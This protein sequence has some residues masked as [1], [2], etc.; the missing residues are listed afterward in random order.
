MI[1][2]SGKEEVVR[3]KRS[4]KLY[5]WTCVKVHGYNYSFTQLHSDFKLGNSGHSSGVLCT[6]VEVH[7]TLG[8]AM[9]ETELLLPTQDVGSDYLGLQ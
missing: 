5:F 6:L 8:Y 7:D 9:N 4:L 1:H 2:F 3:G